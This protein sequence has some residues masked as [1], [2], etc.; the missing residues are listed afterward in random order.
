VKPYKVPSER[1]GIRRS[2]SLK[3]RVEK[4]EGNCRD[5]IALPVGKRKEGEKS[6]FF[7]VPAEAQRG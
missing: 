3:E 1:R 4:K 6:D 5:Q 7:Q 2:C